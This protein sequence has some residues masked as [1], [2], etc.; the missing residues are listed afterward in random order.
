M[1]WK[2][3]LWIIIA[4]VVVLIWIYGPSGAAHTLHSWGDGI[5]TFFNSLKT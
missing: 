1:N 2:R 3:V 5:G 4:I